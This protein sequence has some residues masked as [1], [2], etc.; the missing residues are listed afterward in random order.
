MIVIAVVVALVPLVVPLV[1]VVVVV[2]VV[3]WVSTDPFSCF[4]SLLVH[5]PPPFPSILI[6]FPLLSYQV[7]GV[8]ANDIMAM[9]TKLG[10]TDRLAILPGEVVDACLQKASQ[11]LTNNVHPGR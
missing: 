1:V 7:V 10:I 9:M 8:G 2:V 5:C 4:P 6:P 3:V 11:C